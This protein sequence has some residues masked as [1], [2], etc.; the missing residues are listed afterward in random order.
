MF[1]T[2]SNGMADRM[3]G[4][5][6][7]IMA[8]IKYPAHRPEGAARQPVEMLEHREAEHIAQQVHKQQDH[9]VADGEHHH[10]GQDVDGRAEQGLVQVTA[11]VV[12]FMLAKAP[13]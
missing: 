12:R 6:E 7:K 4:R 3:V 13:D 5:I 11:R 1:C 2:S 10:K 8:T 9:N